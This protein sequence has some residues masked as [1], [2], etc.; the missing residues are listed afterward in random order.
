[1]LN[2]VMLKIYQF[3]CEERKTGVSEKLPDST[4][5]YKW[6]AS[7]YP[8]GVNLYR[9]KTDGYVETSKMMLMRRSIGWLGR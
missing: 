9:L 8:S 5:N 4:L 7:S 2:S 1:M 3:L 6:G